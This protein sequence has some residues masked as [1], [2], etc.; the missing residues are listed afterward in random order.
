M[1]AAPG[2][3]VTALVAVELILLSVILYGAF[4]WIQTLRHSSYF[5]QPSPR[6]GV[7][8]RLA[9]SHGHIQVRSLGYHAILL[10]LMMLPIV[11]LSKKMAVLVDHGIAIVGAPQALGGFLIAVLVLS[12]EGMAAIK[13]AWNNKLQRTMNIALGSALSTI[14]LTIPAVLGISL[15]T[16]ATVELGL[17][18]AEGR[19]LMI[20]LL[21]AVVNFT[22]ERTN[23]LHG[24]VHLAM[25][26]SYVVLIFD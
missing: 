13:A 18:E 14:G 7:T 3:Q 22:M 15:V 9:D 12:P 23:V 26:I 20:T 4:L 16:G 21:V 10:P 5:T 8:E 19:L 17:G 1:P 2:G 24:L 25:F 6:D 11:L